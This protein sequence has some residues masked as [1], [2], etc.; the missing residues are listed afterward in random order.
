[1]TWSEETFRILGLS[2]DWAPVD[3]R[4]SNRKALL[5][6]LH[7]DDRDRYA[8]AIRRGGGGPHEPAARM[9]HPQARR[10]DALDLP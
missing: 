1:M 2:S 5:E 9:P 6:R 4:P 10:N 3:G 7:P 8:A